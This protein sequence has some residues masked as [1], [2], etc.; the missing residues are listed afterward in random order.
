MRKRIGLWSILLVALSCTVIMPKVSLI[1]QTNKWEE[2][3]LMEL[4]S[5]LDIEVIDDGACQQYRDQSIIV[6]SSP[7]MI[8]E[9]Q[10][11][12]NKLRELGYAF[13]VIVLS[14]ELYSGPTDFYPYAKFV[15]RNYW[16]KNFAAFDNVMA[17]ALGYKREFWRDGRAAIKDAQSRYYVWS[18][19]GQITHKPWREAM[20]QSMK[21]I[22]GYTMHETFAFADPN[23]LAVNHYRDLL[24]TTIFAPCP[25]GFWNLDSFRVY[26]ALECG[27]IPIVEKYPVDYFGKFFGAHP[28]L[29][30]ESWD[31]APQLINDLLADPVAL[32]QRRRAC[33]S[34]WCSYKENLHQIFSDTITQAF[35]A[36]A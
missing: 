27:C 26:E 15:F 36:Q 24:L 11:Y 18:F 19:A 35:T 12:F 13:G 30:V 2:D 14:D 3:W 20:A 17:F 10:A 6:I 34:W 16:H 22:D 33:Y 23:G 31:Q 32:E 28:F 7:H 25:R 1:W 5:G 4:L 21:T 29:V 9:Y 8:T